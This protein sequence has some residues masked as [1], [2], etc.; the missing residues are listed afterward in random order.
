MLQFARRSLP[1]QHLCLREGGESEHARPEVL[2]GTK[3][4]APTTYCHRMVFFDL[5]A[6]NSEDNLPYEDDRRVPYVGGVLPYVKVVAQTNDVAVVLTRV[7]AFPDGFEMQI[8]RFVRGAARKVLRNSFSIH[9]C[10]ADDGRVLDEFLR[11]GVSFS[12]GRK[13]TNLHT[14]SP[15]P[16][17]DMPADFGLDC[18][19]GGG[20]DSYYTDTYF[21]WP[22]P[23]EGDFKLVVEWPAVHLAETQLVLDAAEVRSA[24][25]SAKP[26]W[27]E[28]AGKPS[29]ARYSD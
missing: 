23:P 12:D 20:D 19:G 16:E 10:F 18:H 26:V 8:S 6:F 17:A 1:S 3:L 5:P 29:H 25:L 7:V 9:E 13:A 15:E 21:V 4:R 2:S 24:G 11:V 27:P 28:D 14:F 22:L